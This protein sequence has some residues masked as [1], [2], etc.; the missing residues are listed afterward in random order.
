MNT[1]T[2]ERAVT[3]RLAR[4][5]ALNLDPEPRETLEQRYGKVWNTQ[6]LKRDFIVM[7]F[8]APFVVVRRRSDRVRGSLEFQHEPR[9]FFNWTEGPPE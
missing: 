8:F 9:F 3:G 4:L 5:L 1:P 7:G 6:E 2:D